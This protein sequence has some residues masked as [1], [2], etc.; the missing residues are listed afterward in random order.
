MAKK[1]VFPGIFLGL[2]LKGYEFRR[3]V[4]RL[5]MF[6]VYDEV[7]L[8]TNWGHEHNSAIQ[9]ILGQKHVFVCK[10]N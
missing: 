1:D 3:G 7:R 2:D 5:L 10:A 9:S 6:P 8:H 4:Y